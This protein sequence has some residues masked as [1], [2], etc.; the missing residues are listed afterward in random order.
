MSVRTAV[1]DILIDDL[2]D[3]TDVPTDRTGLLWSDEL[4]AALH[5][6]RLGRGPSAMRISG[7]LAR[8]MQTGSTPDAEM[9]ATAL[10]EWSPEFCL[11][12]LANTMGTPYGYE[13]EH[14]GALIQQIVAV[15]GAEDEASSSGSEAR[16]PF[17]TE[18]SFA[19][20]RPDF[21]I[22]LCRR[23]GPHSVPTIVCD[24]DETMANL[25]ASAI[26]ALSLPLF[27]IRSPPSFGL[28]SIVTYG[29]PVLER[30]AAGVGLRLDLPHLITSDS[31][32]GKEALAELFMVIDGAGTPVILEEDEF[33]II[34]NRRAAHARPS[35]MSTF[36]DQQ[37]WLQR[38]LVRIDFWGCRSS[39][40][41]EGVRVSDGVWGGHE[42]GMRRNAA[43]A[44]VSAGRGTY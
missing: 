1:L 25:S 40:E 18:N 15:P 6:M 30:S 33:L 17:H 19:E 4:V 27:E 7:A 23:R 3:S 36:D 14:G 12:E 42:V 11:T 16:L 37:R 20:T 10:T 2:A 9:D 8:A 22:L 35:F 26:E 31:P 44:D 28:P 41:R 13:R 32:Q 39:M 24:V 5:R 34:D 21:V 29:V 43:R 38:S